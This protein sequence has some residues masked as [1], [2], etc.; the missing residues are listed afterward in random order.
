MSSTSVHLLILLKNV[1]QQSPDRSLLFRFL[2]RVDLVGIDGV[3]GQRPAAWESESL[4]VTVDLVEEV[5]DVDPD[6]PESL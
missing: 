5:V 2:L 4:S 1:C 6:S 3:C